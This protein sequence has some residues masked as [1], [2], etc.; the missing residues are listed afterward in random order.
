MK[1]DIDRCIHYYLHMHCTSPCERLQC[2]RG[3]S[4]RSLRFRKT[5]S[6]DNWL[7]LD[8]PILL[9][10]HATA[11]LHATPSATRVNDTVV[12]MRPS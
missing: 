4:P 8:I 7:V 6:L 2:G 3:L 5:Y 10:L 11:T 1:R 12:V 9:T